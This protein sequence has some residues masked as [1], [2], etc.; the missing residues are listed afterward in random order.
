MEGVPGI[1]WAIVQRKRLGGR[2]ASRAMLAL[3]LADQAQPHGSHRAVPVYPTGAGAQRP[4]PKP[5]GSMRPR[6][7][8]QRGLARYQANWRRLM[9]GMRQMGFRAVGA[10]PACQP[11]RGDLP[12]PGSSGVQTSTGAL[13]KGCKRLGYVIFPG[14]LALADTFRVGCMGA[15]TETDITAAMEAVAETMADM[16]ISGLGA[17]SPCH[18]M[19]GRWARA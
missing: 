15:V 12:Q 19:P 8:C 13:S 10:G 14:R 1:G 9:D 2:G 3:D 5:A 7:V 6:A 11:D 16:G 18:V 17:P 4:S